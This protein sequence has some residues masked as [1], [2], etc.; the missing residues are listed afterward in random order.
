MS[1]KEKKQIKQD[2]GDAELEAIGQSIIRFF[3][4]IFAGVKEL[5]SSKFK[6]IGFFI[7]II[8]AIVGF[9]LRDTLVAATGIEGKIHIVKL[10]IYA[11]PALPIAVLILFGLG[12]TN[13]KDDYQKKFEE[14]GF[15]GK[16]KIY[17]QFI[18]QRQDG[19]EIILSFYSAGLTM[20]DWKSKILELETALDCNITK[21]YN[22]KKSKKVIMVHTVPTELGL[23]DNLPWNNEY[24]I[25]KD[26]VL[27]IGKS[28]LED[29]TFDLNKV[30]HGLIAGVTGSGKS[31][32]I[33][34]LLWQ[35]IKKG[36]KVYMLDFK[37][38]VEFGTDYEHFGQV[39]TDR[40]DAVEMLKELTAENALR[41]K[42]FR[43]TGV[44]N[45][46]EYNK[47]FPDNQL[48]RIALFC[49]EVAEML[50]KTGLRKEEKEVFY[51]IEKEMSTLARLSRAPGINM[52]LGTQRPD[53]KVITGQIKNNL[54][55]RISGRMVDEQASLMVL[56]NT[57]ASNMGDTRGRFMY[58]IGSDTYE[59][60]AYNFNDSSV[61]KG[62]YVKGGMLINA[63]D[64]EF[65]ETAVDEMQEEAFESDWDPMQEGEWAEEEDGYEG[66]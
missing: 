62:D 6:C 37:G 54:P 57:K 15:C 45:L 41:L 1:V 63:Y 60:Q 10:A 42:V 34:C 30:P 53:A 48:C 49:D 65:T 36:A 32:L 22:T 61:I 40:Q 24:V 55:I 14:I 3:K 13:M 17:P 47:K 38:G 8:V 46:S 7:S 59:F 52:F 5:K 20:S 50:D 43:Q 11:L 18:S 2:R 39:I 25:E 19:K 26:F 9:I 16:G 31:V 51:D 56:G 44:K 35:C 33:R 4:A 29:V 66:F 58:T 21:I 23:E 12:K 28:M 64:D 27:T